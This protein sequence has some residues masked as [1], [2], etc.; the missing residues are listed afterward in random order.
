MDEAEELFER[1]LATRNDLGLLAEEWD[2]ESRRQLGNYPQAFTHVALVN[3]AFNLDRQH[4]A[5]P[6]QRSR[7]TGY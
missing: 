3:S 5:T 1:C 2:P 6:H 4:H 7:T